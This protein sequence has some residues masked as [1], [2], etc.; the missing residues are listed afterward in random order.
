V[1]LPE[2]EGFWAPDALTSLD[3]NDEPVEANHGDLDISFDAALLYPGI[4]SPSSML[5]LAVAMFE[6]VFD[7][8]L[9]SGE[10]LQSPKLRVSGLML[11]PTGART[12]SSS[13]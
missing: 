2:A 3:I 11:L 1:S 9:L 4:G 6:T 10:R 8:G 13:E 5:F 12:A 7:M